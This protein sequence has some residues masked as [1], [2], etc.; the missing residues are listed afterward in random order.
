MADD[1]RD[2]A[3]PSGGGWHIGIVGPGSP[4]VPR[5]EQF[6]PARYNAETEL[7]IDVPPA[8]IRGLDF[9]LTTKNP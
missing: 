9:E 5:R 3:R 4:A 7:E 2:C 1:L 6:I 8:G